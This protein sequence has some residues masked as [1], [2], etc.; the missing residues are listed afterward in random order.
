M[1]ETPSTDSR[2]CISDRHSLTMN[3]TVHG[4]KKVT[5]VLFNNGS[6]SFET[7][8]YCQFVS[9]IHRGRLLMISY[10]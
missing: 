8:T 4:E 1:D 2:K 9:Q 3:E 10:W 5:S 7:R 6:I